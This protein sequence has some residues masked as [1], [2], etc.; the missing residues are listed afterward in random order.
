V[1]DVYDAT[2]TKRV[3]KE[4]IPH[5]EA[6]AIMQE[7]CGSQFD[8]DVIERLLGDPLTSPLSD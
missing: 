2:T 5:S 7:G 4:A 6:M 1:T 3:Y 8:P